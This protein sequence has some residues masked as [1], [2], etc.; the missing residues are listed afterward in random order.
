MLSHYGKNVYIYNELLT[1]EEIDEILEKYDNSYDIK[2]NKKSYR[3]CNKKVIYDEYIAKMIWNKLANHIDEL[4]VNESMKTWIPF[5]C[6]ERIKLIKYDP[7]DHFDWHVDASS[8]IDNKYKVTFSVTIYLNTVPKKNNGTT[9]FKEN[10]KLSNIQ[11]VKGQAMLINT[12]H[13]PEH[14]GEQL[15]N[16]VKYILRLDVLS[17]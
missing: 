5:C 1:D 7:G 10:S 8:I 17:K 3:K 16:G 14:C 2:F 4:T 12:L 15:K 13:G 6:S 9:M 11:P